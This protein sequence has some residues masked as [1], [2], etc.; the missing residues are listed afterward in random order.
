MA[1]RSAASTPSEAP[2]SRIVVTPASSARRAW[3]AAHNACAGTERRRLS[4]ASRSQLSPTSMLRCVWASTMPG[5]SVASPS[6]TTRAPG[7]TG[8]ALPMAWMRPP[9]TSTT[10]S[11]TLVSP[12]PSNSRAA[13][14][15]VTTGAGGA[16]VGAAPKVANSRAMA[17]KRYLPGRVVRRRGVSN[18]RGHEVVCRS[19]RACCGRRL[20]D[21]AG[22]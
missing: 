16:V 4:T 5:S 21:P 20:G 13:F 15:A 11:R 2:T 18:A 17:S 19:R 3:A 7:G 9:A 22:Q 8:K 1:S 10:A 12:R 14:S 6:S